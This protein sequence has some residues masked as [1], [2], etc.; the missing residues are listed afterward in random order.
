ML[1]SVH[2]IFFLITFTSMEMPVDCP[3]MLQRCRAY[4][5]LL[6]TETMFR[7]MRSSAFSKYTKMGSCYTLYVPF[8]NLLLKQVGI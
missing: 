4:G 5:D 1:G 8:S 7:F 2:F 3:E 6:N